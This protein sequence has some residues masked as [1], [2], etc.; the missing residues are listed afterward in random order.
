MHTYSQ[1][2]AN[3]RIKPKQ[4]LSEDG[5]P[6]AYCLPANTTRPTDKR[7]NKTQHS[8]KKNKQ[9]CLWVGSQYIIRLVLVCRCDWRLGCRAKRRSERTADQTILPNSIC[10][11]TRT[12]Q[13]TRGWKQKST[14]R[15]RVPLAGAQLLK[16]TRTARENCE[17]RFLPRA[18]TLAVQ[19]GS[20]PSSHRYKNQEL[21]YKQKTRTSCENITQLNIILN[22]DK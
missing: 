19:G 5:R 10:W 21:N 8:H 20:E 6:C 18:K 11:R 9:S 7:E 4:T 3:T 16:S 17:A 12:T 15:C 2:R 14:D 22:D 1:A 13:E